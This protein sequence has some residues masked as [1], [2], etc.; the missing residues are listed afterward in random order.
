M[1]CLHKDGENSRQGDFQYWSMA[2]EAKHK[3]KIRGWKLKKSL[4]LLECVAADRVIE[5]PTVVVL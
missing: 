1:H 4:Q 5:V 3:G 2:Q